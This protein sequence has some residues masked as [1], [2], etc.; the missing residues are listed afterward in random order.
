MRKKEREVCVRQINVA[1][2]FFF[3]YYYNFTYNFVL[4]ISFLFF[5]LGYIRGVIKA[6]FRL[7]EDFIYTRAYFTLMAYIYT[8]FRCLTVEVDD[9]T[10]KFTPSLE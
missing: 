7:M 8:Q 10:Y 9:P 4:G 6:T 1:L 2:K 5:S 3:V